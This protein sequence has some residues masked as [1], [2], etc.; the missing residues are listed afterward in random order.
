MTATPRPRVTWSNLWFWKGYF[1]HGGT[2]G[3]EVMDSVLVRDS[4]ALNA[5]SSPG[6]R[7]CLEESSR[8][9]GDWLPI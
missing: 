6:F 3:L 9:V 1:G 4:E 5:G 8:R 2:D 7:G